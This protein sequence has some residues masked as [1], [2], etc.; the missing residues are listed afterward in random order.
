[1]SGITQV[2]MSFITMLSL[3]FGTLG[4]SDYDRQT[5]LKEAL[6]AL[7][8]KQQILSEK[9]VGTE[10]TDKWDAGKEYRLEDTVVL[11]KKKGEDF[12][13]LNLADV[14]FSD[15]DY[16]AFYAFEGTLTIKRLVAE[17]KPDLIT[18]S[19]DIVCG[20]SDKYSIARFT[21]LMESFGI[22]WA[23]IFGNHDNEANCDINYL[24]E[25]MMKSPHCVMQKGDP[26][27]G[28]GNYI[29]NIVEDNGD[30]T[31]TPC[32]SLIMYYCR[33]HDV[34][35]LKAWYTW[36]CDGIK[37]IG[38][39][40]V[41]T[42]L[43]SHIPIAEYQYAYDEAWDEAVG[44]WKDGY[45]AYGELHETVCA[46]YDS[47]GKPVLDG[48]FDTIK[49]NGTKYFFCSHDH[50]NNFSIEYEGVRLTYMMKLGYG[51][52]FQPGFNGGTVIRIGDDGINRIIHKTVSYGFMRDIVDIDTKA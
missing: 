34:E 40:K 36:A 28:V 27:M 45:K 21:D 15:Y 13:I 37:A 2:I 50:M 41:E 16:R 18:V 31:V 44:K 48:F 10:S 1:M 32:E 30:G 24:A 14:H 52:G 3:F 43:F 23:P 20:K 39:E 19:G 6:D 9:Y 12:V 38:D 47:D 49:D 17:V 35:K 42:V 22:P 4:S 46:D 8:N 26:S 5:G 7:V 25:T 29:V 51:S 33:F 11:T